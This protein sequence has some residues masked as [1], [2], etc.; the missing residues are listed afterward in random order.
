MAIDTAR[1]R[2]DAAGVV[3]LP[4]TPGVTPGTV[5]K[6]WRW[7][8]AWSYVP[9][10]DLPSD[11]EVVPGTWET[12]GVTGEWRTPSVGGSWYVNL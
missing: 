6:R 2:R 9:G 11:G 5:N 4:L 1:K 7:A 10:D 12:P 3:F 8:A